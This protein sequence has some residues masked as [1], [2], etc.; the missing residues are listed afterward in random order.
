MPLIRS[1]IGYILHERA[2]QYDGGGSGWLSIKTF[3]GG[4]AH[5]RVGRRQYRVDERAFLLLNHDQHYALTI[6]ADQPV[7]SLCLFWSPQATAQAHASLVTPDDRLLLDPHAA[8]PLEVVERTYRYDQPLAALL[9]D[10]PAALPAA[11]PAAIDEHL[12]RVLLRI[13]AAQREIAREIAALPAAR[14]ATR[15]EL[16]RRVHHACDYA[17]ALLDTPLTLSDL[18]EVAGLSP[19]HL[20]RAFR[21]VVGRTPHQYLTEL[22][23][24]RACHLLATTDQPITEICFA[25]GFESLGA[26]SWRFRQRVGCAPSE[27]RRQTR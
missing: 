23:L 16:Y 11:T 18:A 2:P 5:Y 25:V 26:F 27:Y 7:E 13:V 4:A 3:R 8:R 1:P 19:N 12:H 22:R 20:L 9:H 21:Q 15:A 6:D 24:E 10:L 14:A 17:A